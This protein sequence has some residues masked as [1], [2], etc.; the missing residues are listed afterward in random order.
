MPNSRVEV[1][2]AFTRVSSLPF[3][4]V[5]EDAWF[6]SA[7][8]YVYENGLMNGTTATTF[9]PNATTSRGMIVA[10]LWR[11]AGRPHSGLPDGI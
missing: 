8:E 2:V 4:D 10:I 3:A 7:V 9:T 11:Q 1:Q 5:A 6:R